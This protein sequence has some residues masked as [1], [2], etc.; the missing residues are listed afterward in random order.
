MLF[1]EEGFMEDKGQQSFEE[2]FPSLTMRNMTL[3]DRNEDVLGLNKEKG[4]K[5]AR[6]IGSLY[7]FDDRSNYS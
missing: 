3:G 6:F 1:N 7:N 5:F 4:A 2:D